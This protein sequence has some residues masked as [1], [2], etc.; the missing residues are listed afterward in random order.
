MF[1]SATNLLRACVQLA[2]DLLADPS[3]SQDLLRGAQ[4]QL[5]AALGHP[6]RRAL[7]WRRDRRPGSIPPPPAHCLSPVRGGAASSSG[8]VPARHLSRDSGQAVVEVPYDTTELPTEAGES[9]E[10][11]REDRQSG[12]LWC[13]SETG[14]EGWVP[15][16]TLRE[17]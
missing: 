13:R 3:D 1:Q 14:R 4:D 6:H 15:L 7:R 12:W 5:E 9:L 2:D 11:V 17:P 8:W 10:V 16:S